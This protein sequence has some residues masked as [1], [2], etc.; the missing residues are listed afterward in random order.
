LYIRGML[1][2]LLAVLAPVGAYAYLIFHIS[3]THHWP[4]KTELFWHLIT[5]AVTSGALGAVV[6]VILR[7]SNR[8]LSIAYTAGRNLIWL[9]GFFRPIV[10]AI[11]GLV[12]YVLINAGL[13]QVL[14]SPS[15]IE[16]LAY[17]VAAVCFAAGFSERRAQDFIV[18]V[19][20]TQEGT[21]SDAVES[22]ARRPEES[23]IANNTPAAQPSSFKPGSRQ[24]RSTTPDGPGP[25][26]V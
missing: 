15:T 25:T 14:G 22:P 5:I 6:S 12:F 9:A 17:F 19:L 4:S 26:T 11:F 13:L 20:P 2:G 8:P 23:R 3:A 7:I 24:S 16:K 18:R 10:G 21:E 1:I